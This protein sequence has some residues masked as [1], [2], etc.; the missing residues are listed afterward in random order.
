MAKLYLANAFSINMVSNYIEKYGPVAL[1]V[2]EISLDMVKKLANDIEYELV[3]AIGHEGTAKLVG[4]LIN[5]ELKANRIE[6][7]MEESD[8]IVVVQLLERL[9]ESK[10]LSHEEIMD[11]YNKGKV[12]FYRVRH[13]G[14][15]DDMDRSAFL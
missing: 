13:L 11:Y 2:D 12:K 4:D 5:K 3:N 9:P 1:L 7:K 6:I 15:E 14:Y 10:V 8:T